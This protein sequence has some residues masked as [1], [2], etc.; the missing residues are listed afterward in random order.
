MSPFRGSYIV[1]TPSK[2]VVLVTRR[3]R[4]SWLKAQ[5]LSRRT[6]R[7]RVL[8]WFR[9]RRRG[10]SVFAVSGL[11]HAIVLALMALI[12]FGSVRGGPGDEGIHA[13]F[14]DARLADLPPDIEDEGLSLIALEGRSQSGGAGNV[15]R[16]TAAARLSTVLV[17]PELAAVG[18]GLRLAP[19]LMP[20]RETPPEFEAA[21][22][23]GPQKKGNGGESKSQEQVDTGLERL[24]SQFNG[25]S[26]SARAGLVKAFGGNEASEAAVAAGLKWLAEHQRGDGSW[27]FNHVTPACDATCTH[28]G[29]PLLFDC[30]IGATGLA[31]LA[32]LGAGQTPQEGDYQRQVAAGLEYLIKNQ[33]PGPGGHGIDFRDGSLP[34]GPMYVQAIATMALSEAYAMTGD[35]RL[36]G[37]AQGGVDFIA[38]SQ[39]PLGGGWR[40]RPQAPGDTSVVGWQAMALTSARVARLDVPR[41]VIPKTLKFLRSV[42]AGVGYGYTNSNPRPS[43]TAI[44]LLCKM[45]LQANATRESFRQ[46]AL[47]VSDIGPSRDDMYYNY[48]ATQFMHQYGEDLWRKW[49]ERMRD[50]LIL[51]QEKQGHAA[52]SWAPRDR[53]GLMAG[54]LYVTAMSVMTLEVY[55]RHLPLYQHG[56]DL[57]LNIHP[58]AAVEPNAGQ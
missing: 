25:R 15:F 45:Y 32:F 27:S 7:Q 40:Y 49:N 42:Q 35:R 3:A 23:S 22:G 55:Y 33:R 38:W 36:R 18:P 47:T 53:H 41:P 26:A 6:W 14:I 56:V 50:W 29:T 24:K 9:Q 4:L 12:I 39:D 13:E 17:V 16:E 58:P 43:T 34:S 1:R 19:A 20:A 54:R 2:V 51:T 8:E 48:Y 44:G 21:A 57:D 30:E 10:F 52:G 46:G 28:P 31:L 5:E 37:P 11:I